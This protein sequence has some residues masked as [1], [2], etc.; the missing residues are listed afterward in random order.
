MKKLTLEENIRR[1]FVKALKSPD[2]SFFKFRDDGIGLVEFDC[3]VKTSDPEK[4]SMVLWFRK[5]DRMVKTPEGREVFLPD[6]ID[7]LVSQAEKLKGEI[8][9]EDERLHEI[10]FRNIQKSFHTYRI[11][12][13]IPSKERKVTITL[14]QT[15]VL[16]D[17]VVYS[18]WKLGKYYMDG[19]KEVGFFPSLNRILERMKGYFK[20]DFFTI[21]PS[22]LRDYVVREGLTV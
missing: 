1:R 22:G 9:L 13:P 15:S 11:E 4:R 10:G 17:P 21:L 12:F 2:P 16:T 8:I 6:E 7:L 3:H 5:A 20:D 18:Y 19:G 14:S